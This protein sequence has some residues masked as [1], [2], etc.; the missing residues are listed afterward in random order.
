MFLILT[1]DREPRKHSPAF[2]LASYVFVMREC[3]R[4]VTAVL[5]R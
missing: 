3:H 5:L 4:Y 2:L 1:S